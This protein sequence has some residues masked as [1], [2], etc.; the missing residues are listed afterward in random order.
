[1]AKPKAPRKRSTRL[2]VKT[3]ARPAQ[4][5]EVV[6]AAKI[7]SPGGPIPIPYPNVSRKKS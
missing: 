7:P 3:N 5:R 1:M 6:K 4:R 2:R